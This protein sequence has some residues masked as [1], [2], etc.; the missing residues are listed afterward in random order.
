VFGQRQ[1]RLQ[2]VQAVDR[3]R[4]EPASAAARKSAC[5]WLFPSRQ[6]RSP[7]SSTWC[8]SVADAAAGVDDLALQAGAQ[9]RR[10]RAPA[11]AARLA[12]CVFQLAVGAFI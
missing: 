7:H 8:S 5:F 11:A 2:H 9:P 1:H 12:C 10:R 3:C 4:V 6:T